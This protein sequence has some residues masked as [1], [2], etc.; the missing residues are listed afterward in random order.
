[1][2]FSAMSM[3]LDSN[4]FS[5]FQF[6]LEL[7]IINIIFRSSSATNFCSGP[8]FNKIKTIQLAY[9]TIAEI[10]YNN[11]SI[12]WYYQTT[13][14]LWNCFIPASGLFHFWNL[15]TLYNLVNKFYKKFYSV[16]SPVFLF[17][18]LHQ[19]QKCIIFK[20]NFYWPLHRFFEFRRWTWKGHE[21]IRINHSSQL[22]VA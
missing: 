7:F 3:L 16:I 18:A 15:R 20:K 13:V 19:F 4:P 6:L 9:K 5:Y 11:H 14:N 21:A 1:M 2:I 10:S 22:S 8:V 12:N 17:I